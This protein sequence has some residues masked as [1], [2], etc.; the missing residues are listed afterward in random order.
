MN[1]IS[2]YHAPA[3]TRVLPQGQLL[4]VFS[5]TLV[6]VTLI[7]I[8]IVWS[9]RRIRQHQRAFWVPLAAGG[10]AALVLLVG[11]LALMLIDPAL[12]IYLNT[13]TG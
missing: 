2:Q 8:A 5:R 12:A 1:A 10:A 6:Y 9:A 3:Q 4:V 11:I 7:L 13:L